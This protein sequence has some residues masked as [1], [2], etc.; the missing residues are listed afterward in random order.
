LSLRLC[1]NLKES[2]LLDI[3]K[4][5]VVKDICK[6][7]EFVE[8]HNCP[9]PVVAMYNYV[10]TA[11]KASAVTHAAVGS[12]LSPNNRDLILAKCSRMEIYSLSSEG[13]VPVIELPIYGRIS[14]MKLCRFP[15]D[16]QDCLFFLTE[17]YKFAVLRWNTQT[18]ECDTIAGGDVHDRIGHPTSAGHIGKITCQVFSER[19]A[20]IIFKASTTL[21]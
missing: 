5:F 20:S 3:F 4:E 18:G 15:D 2:Q 8:R 14:V 19:R 11:H 21:Q 9:R 13:L 1:E 10:V 6:I 17:K 12:F 16:L 7:I